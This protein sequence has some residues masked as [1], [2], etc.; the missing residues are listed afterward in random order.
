MRSNLWFAFLI[1]TGLS[2]AFEIVTGGRTLA[3]IPDFLA[4]AEAA[5]L[6]VSSIGRRDDVIRF[7]TLCYTEGRSRLCYYQ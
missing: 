5:P 6:P 3:R 4:R 2:L 1:A 7:T